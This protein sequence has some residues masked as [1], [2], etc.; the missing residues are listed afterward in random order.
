[1]ILYDV[2]TTAGQSGSSIFATTPNFVEDAKRREHRQNF[3]NYT[4]AVIG[5]HTGYNSHLSLN[6]GTLLTQDLRKWISSEIKDH[7]ER[8]PKRR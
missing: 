3:S 7:K 4:K 5:V 6:A 8:F 2:D 1:M